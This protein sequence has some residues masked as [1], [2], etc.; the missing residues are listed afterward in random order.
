MTSAHVPVLVVG[1][2]LVGLSAALF[3]EYHGVPYVLVERRGTPSPL[4]R[5]RGLHTRTGEMYRQV[6][7]E[8]RILEVAATALKAGKFGG[9]WTGGS[10]RTAEALDLSA[11]GASIAAGADPSPAQFVFVPQV[12]L[13][14][15]LA[16]AARERGGDL[17]FGTELVEFAQDADGV[18]AVLRDAAGARSVLRADYLIAADGAGSPIRQA[19]GITGT[20]LPPTHHYLN[21]FARTDLTGILDGRGFSQCEITGPQVRGLVLTKNNTDEWSFHIEYDPALESPA[22]WPD[23]RVYAAI[24]TMVGAP[25]LE[26][27]I[28]ARSAWD[29]GAFVADEYRRDRVFL[30]G[31]AA[32]RHAPWGGY[33]GNTGVA[34]AHNL[35]WK[36]AA[37][38][39]GTAGPALLDSYAAE[40]RPRAQV[41][42][43]Q[44]RLGTD[45]RTRYGIPTPDNAGDLA[46]RLDMSAVMNRYRYTSSAVLDTA[47][48]SPHVP[49]LHGQT[50]TRLPHWWVDAGSWTLST[51]DLCGPGFT[52]LIAGAA[53][54]WREAAAKA[55]RDTGIDIAVHALPVSDCA[56]RAGLAEGKAL[57]IRPD[58]HI[59]A[60][61]D[62]G[63][64]PAW[65]GEVL[66]LV[67]DARNARAVLA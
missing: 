31:D 50:G 9:A 10:V 65:L 61:P 52:L 48:S 8:A 41:A 51:L 26:V 28:L 58:H 13:E 22:D 24:R 2:G 19:L 21:V 29:T 3:L 45:F 1:G 43:E 56:E 35:V 33:G 18:T 6:G 47:D 34:D 32:H 17:R 59:A 54:A 53:G 16:E 30:V 64:T 37:T 67:S 15:V 7:L 14:P 57:L 42:V 20:E 60:G 38:L 27:E 46:R 36:L 40:R 5:S 49:A 66:E 4:P 23:D 63:L 55:Q 12:Q 11:F 39:R 62:S 44:S 25:D